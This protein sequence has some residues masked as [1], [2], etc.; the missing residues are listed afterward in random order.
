[1][2]ALML[3]VR[4]GNIPDVVVF[5]DGFND[6]MSAYQMGEAGLPQNEFKRVREFNSSKLLNAIPFRK[7]FAEKLSSVRLAK[8]LLYRAGFMKTAEAS[9]PDQTMTLDGYTESKAEPLARGVVEAYRTN[10]ETVKALSQHFGFQVLFYWQP[11]LYDKMPL[12]AYEEDNK[13]AHA[14]FQKFFEKT[15]Q[16]IRTSNVERSH[17]GMFHDLSRVFSDTRDPVFVDWCHMGEKGNAL[18]ADR[19]MIDILPLVQRKRS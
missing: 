16:A 18:I 14:K 6:T 2:I 7:A 1:M 9:N 3:E 19:M 12:T 5:Y 11:L 10:L 15:Y 4:K 13:K 17:A 8:A